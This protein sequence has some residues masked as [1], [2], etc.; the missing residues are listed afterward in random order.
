MLR[1]LRARC[2][3]MNTPFCP[4]VL[5]ETGNCVFCGKLRADEICDC[6]WQGVC[7]LYEKMWQGKGK[8]QSKNNTDLPRAE[9]LA[10]IVD[11]REINT[12]VCR[13]TCRVPEKLAAKLIAPGSFVFLRKSA[14]PQY[15]QLPIGIMNVDGQNIFMV[16]EKVGT[17]S[18]RVIEAEKELVIRGPY[19]NGILGQPWVEKIAYGNVLMVVG[20]MGQPPALLIAKNLVKN[21]NKVT[22]VIAP[23]SV[24]S[25]FIAEDLQRLNINLIT[26]NSLRAQGYNRAVQEVLQSNYDLI[27]SCGPDN[28][29]QAIIKAIDDAAIDIPMAATN[30]SVMCCGEGVCGSCERTTAT[31]QK[32]RTCKVQMEYRQLKN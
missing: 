29:H 8:N 13:I 4:C 25:I 27:V 5:A 10:E 7:I 30:N 17:K 1:K 6:N 23:G 3:D 22:A 19:F 11:K 14:D 12:G 9:F 28:Q 15:F 18:A 31:G 2:I 24:G 26:V 32:V 16:I 20:G 21:Y